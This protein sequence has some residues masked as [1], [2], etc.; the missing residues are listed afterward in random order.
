MPIEE[1]PLVQLVVAV[2]TK[3]MGEVMVVLDGEDTVTVEKAGSANS[4]THQK[5][6]LISCC[7]EKTFRPGIKRAETKLEVHQ[8]TINAC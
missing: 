3:R 2:A 8:L 5:K 4:K 6:H 7:L 1:M